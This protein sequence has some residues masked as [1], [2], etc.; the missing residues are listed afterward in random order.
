MVPTFEGEY[1]V[2]REFSGK[3]ELDVRDSQGDWDAFLPEKAPE[4]YLDLEAH[5]AAAYA[6]D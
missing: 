3:I 4:G 6:R 5:L 2:G 1:A